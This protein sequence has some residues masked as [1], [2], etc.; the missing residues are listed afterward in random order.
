MNQGD[1]GNDEAEHVQY[2]S[3]RQNQKKMKRAKADE[4]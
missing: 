2:Y 3:R 1:R 4:D